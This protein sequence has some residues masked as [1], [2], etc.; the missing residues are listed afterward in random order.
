MRPPAVRLPRISVVVPSYNQGHFLGEAL[1]SLF[2]Q[3]YPD[4]EVVVMDGGSADDSV[5][6]I[7]RYADRLAYWQ[8]R[9]DGG[10]SAAINAGMARCTGDLVAWLNADDYYWRDAL[11]VVGRAFAAHPGR[12]LY[13]GNGFRFDQ[14]EKRHTPFNPRH[15]ALNR[16]ALRLGLDY[17]LRP[18]SFFL[19]TAWQEAGGLRPELEFCMDWDVLLRIADRHPAVLINEFLAVSREYRD[20]KTS[21]GGLR[22]AE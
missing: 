4:L 6:V 10:Q 5:A 20:T 19:R 9:R 12:G 14:A 21:R 16:R 3:G 18:S 11:W 17:L 8:S 15:M 2:G 1:A 7:R 22:R 13:L